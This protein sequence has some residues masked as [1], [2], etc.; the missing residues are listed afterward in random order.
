MAG[1]KMFRPNPPKTPLAHDEGKDNPYDR[2]PEVLPVPHFR[3]HGE[4]EERAG[5]QGRFADFG[6]FT[7]F[8]LFHDPF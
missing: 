8:S 4:G 2:N 1:L 3:G 5:H 6:R 7:F